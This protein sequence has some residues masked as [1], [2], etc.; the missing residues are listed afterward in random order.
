M[1]H[2]SEQIAAWSYAAPRS[3]NSK[4]VQDVGFCA[5]SAH[6]AKSPFKDDDALKKQVLEFL[7]QQVI[8]GEHI[9]ESRS[10]RE[11]RC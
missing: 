1:P 8:T 10:R 4:N 11:T 3:G 7:T 2:P 6:E 9:C 5:H